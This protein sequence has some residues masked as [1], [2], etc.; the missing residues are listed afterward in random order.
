M[1]V[2]ALELLILEMHD[3]LLP[4]EV[5]DDVKAA[6][7][8]LEL[9]SLRHSRWHLTYTAA[10][11]IEDGAYGLHQI[12]DTATWADG[13]GGQGMSDLIAGRDQIRVAVGG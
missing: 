10:D 11:E 1:V 9:S 13:E 12:L 4:R 7:E 3:E 6:L 5:G 2:L 8:R